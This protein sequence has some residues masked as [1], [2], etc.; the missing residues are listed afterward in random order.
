MLTAAKAIVAALI[1]GLSA[2]GA[3]FQ[4]NN[5]HNPGTVGY[6]LAA[7]A[8]LTAFSATYFVVNQPPKVQ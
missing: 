7:T 3:E 1:S 6:L 2:L 8:T 5:G 4:T